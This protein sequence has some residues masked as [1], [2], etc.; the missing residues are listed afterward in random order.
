MAAAVIAFCTGSYTIVR[1]GR[2]APRWQR[3]R[4][5]GQM[6]GGWRDGA[7]APEARGMQA[8]TRDR[9]VSPHHGARRPD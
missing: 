7:M 1:V 9:L 5:P 6:A 3:R 8:L 4:L 2:D